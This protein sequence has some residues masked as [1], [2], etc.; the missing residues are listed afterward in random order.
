MEKVVKFSS[1]I[2][3]LLLFV[4]GTALADITGTWGFEANIDATECGDGMQ[5][6]EL[7]VEITRSGDTYV[8]AFGKARLK[9]KLVGDKLT[10]TGSYQDEGTVTKNLTFLIK[11][12]QMSGGGEW[13]Y[14]TEGFKCQGTEKLQGIK[15]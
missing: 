9:G 1:V 7:E 10:V 15:L 11:G 2:A 4:A 6:Q 12:S 13:T 14:A 3:L 5:Q 8:F